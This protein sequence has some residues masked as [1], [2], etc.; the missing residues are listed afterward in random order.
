MMT[1]SEIQQKIPYGSNILINCPNCWFKWEPK[2]HK[3]WNNLIEA[4]LWLLLLIPWAIYDAWRHIH[5]IC[6]CPKCGETYL[7]E[8]DWDTNLITSLMKIKKKQMVRFWIIIIFFPL[9][10]LTAYFENNSNQPLVDSHINTRTI[11]SDTTTANS[12]MEKKNSSTKDLFDTLS[13][14]ID[15][16]TDEEKYQDY[17]NDIAE[18]VTPK[19]E[20]KESIVP[21]TEKKIEEEPK[22][23]K[24]EVREKVQNVLKQIDNQYASTDWYIWA[25]CLGD[26][27]NWIINVDFS[28]DIGWYDFTVRAH[29]AMLSNKI[30]Q[31][32]PNYFDQIWVSFNYNWQTVCSCIFKEY[33]RN[34]M[35]PK[36]CT[37][38]WYNK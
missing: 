20:V 26:C 25:S 8:T 34:T 2:K 19:Q 11:K 21:E 33:Q 6:I 37:W 27:I 23:E 17:L 16:L 4:I 7:E 29:A 30:I 22:D 14:P 35:A 13:K 18:S 3:E 15:N 38:F 5:T 24:E 32:V 28:K 9:L 1:D 31:A 10:W 36:W 12:N